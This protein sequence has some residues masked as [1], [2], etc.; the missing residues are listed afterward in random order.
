M[1]VTNPQAAIGWEALA[2]TRNRMGTHS[3]EVEIVVQADI[4]AP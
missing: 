3:I 1:V 2:I 4:L